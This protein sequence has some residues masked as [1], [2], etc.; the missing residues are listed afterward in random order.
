MENQATVIYNTIPKKKVSYK[1]S[2]ISILN[3]FSKISHNLLLWFYTTKIDSD[4]NSNK[5]NIQHIAIQNQ[6][7][8][9]YN[10]TPKEKVHTRRTHMHC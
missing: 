6:A 9:I 3:T 8:I 4:Q 10:T 5:Y 2:Y 7:T 1:M